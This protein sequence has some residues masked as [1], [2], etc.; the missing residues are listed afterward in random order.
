MHGIGFKVA[1]YRQ[2]CMLSRQAIAANGVYF[3]CHDEEFD[4]ERIHY[5]A[6]CLAS[7]LRKLSI[8][9][10]SNIIHSLFEPKPIELL[11]DSLYVF[12][13]T[14]KSYSSDYMQAIADYPTHHKVIICTADMS[15]ELVTPPDIL[16]FVAHEN[17]FLRV[18]GHRKAWAFGLSDNILSQASNNTPFPARRKVVLRNFRPSFNQSVRNCLDLCLLPHLKKHFEIDWEISDQH[19]TKLKTYFGCLAYGGHFRENLM[20]NPFFATREEYQHYGHAFTYLKEPVITRWDSW[21]FWESLAAGCLTFH[22]DF[23]KY[24]FQLPVMPIAWKHYIPI[25]LE[26]PKG[27]VEQLMDRMS[28]LSTISCQGQVW[29]KQ[30]Y[31]ID[32]ATQ[33]FLDSVTLE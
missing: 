4:G 18:I 21:R 33:R 30:N 23:E 2:A 9:V 31:A 6:Q 25:D 5:A 22:L 29:A 8:P 16:S 11:S 13:V 32:A 20:R 7:G 3:Y 19:F 10:F 15:N 28:E 17:R 24:G 1:L 27:T 26:D 14:A 12:Q